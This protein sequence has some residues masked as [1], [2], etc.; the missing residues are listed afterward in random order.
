M[1]W[2]LIVAENCCRDDESIVKAS[3]ALAAGV[4]VMS[5]VVRVKIA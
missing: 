3:K 5:V 4:V 1:C 2:K